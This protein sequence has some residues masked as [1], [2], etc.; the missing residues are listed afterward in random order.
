MQQCYVQVTSY[1]LLLNSST[2][3]QEAAAVGTLPFYL[4]ICIAK[5]TGVKGKGKYPEQAKF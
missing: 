3:H 2:K 4:Q 5:I 1:T